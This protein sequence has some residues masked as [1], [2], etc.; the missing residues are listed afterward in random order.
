MRMG[1]VDDLRRKV[2]LPDKFGWDFHNEMGL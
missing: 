1:T 2:W